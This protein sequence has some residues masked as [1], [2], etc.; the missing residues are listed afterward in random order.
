MK[1]NSLLFLVLLLISTCATSNDS[2]SIV[3]NQ[4]DKAP[5][6]SEAEKNQ[7]FIWGPSFYSSIVDIYVYS[8]NENIGGGTGTFISEDGLIITN[9][10]VTV[11]GDKFEVFTYGTFDKITEDFIDPETNLKIEPI[12]AILLGSSQCND[13]AVLQINTDKKNTYLEWYGDNIL[14]GLEIYTLGYPAV[15]DGEI[16]VT[17]GVVSYVNSLG[18][19]PWTAPG[20]NTFAHTSPIFSGNSGGPVVTAEG[21]LVGI[22]Y[23]T[24]D[25]IDESFPISK[26]LN[27]HHIKDLVENYLLMGENYMDIGIG[28][29]AIDL[30]WY[31]PE[32][33]D[34]NLTMHYIDQVQPG[35]SGEIAGLMKDSLLL[36]VGNNEIGFIQ[37][38]TDES[39]YELC[40]KIKEWQEGKSD[41]LNYTLYSCFDESFYKGYI[42]KEVST[43]VTELIDNPYKDSGFSIDDFNL[44]CSGYY[45]Y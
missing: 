19:S 30:Y 45:Q 43:R 23:L 16:A 5:S 38:G 14:P 7:F 12:E 42:S 28:S 11:G 17:T 15:A 40:N 41:L 20:Y 34:R 37:T 1:K 18:D 29:T 13:I 25:L 44:V 4:N 24:E 22:N 27:N 33:D 2:N 9:Q 26:A 36:E 21:K 31:L 3:N 35:S 10:H 32:T 39:S 6:F 8:D